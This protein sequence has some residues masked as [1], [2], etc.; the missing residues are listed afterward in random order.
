MG[1]SFLPQASSPIS[2]DLR[3]QGDFRARETGGIRD[4]LR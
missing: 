3:C 2:A 1:P 4:F